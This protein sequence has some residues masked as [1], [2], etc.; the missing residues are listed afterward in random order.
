MIDRYSLVSSKDKIFKALGKVEFTSDYYLSYS[1]SPLDHS[2]IITQEERKLV[3]KYRWGLLPAWS[4]QGINCGNLYNARSQGIVSKPSYRIPIRQKRCLV[5][6]DSFYVFDKT[7]QPYRV[8]KRNKGVILLA[9][10]YDQCYSGGKEQNTFTIITNKSNKEVA[11]HHDV[12]PVI[13]DGDDVN[14]W[15]DNSSSINQVLDLLSPNENYTIS[16]YKVSHQLKDKEF[17]NPILHEEV[18]SDMTLFDLQ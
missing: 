8:Y 10:L 18:V 1:I 2:Y 4:R 14:A 7:G 9:G 12:S 11:R 16:L 13:L 15:L 17:N 6:A 5:L 3:Q